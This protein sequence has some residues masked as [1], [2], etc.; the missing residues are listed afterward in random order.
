MKLLAVL[1]LAIPSFAQVNVNAP[2]PTAPGKPPS[3]TIS[4]GILGNDQIFCGNV[5]S[6]HYAISPMKHSV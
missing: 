1:L 5:K 4:A 2:L 3:G 6:T